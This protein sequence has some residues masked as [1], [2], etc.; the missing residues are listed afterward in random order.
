M[1]TKKT[2]AQLLVLPAVLV[3]L[4]ASATEFDQPGDGPFFGEDANG[5][6]LIGAKYVDMNNRDDGLGEEEARNAGIIL[7]YEFA[8]PVWKGKAAFEFQYLPSIEWGDVNG[9]DSS[10]PSIYPNGGRWENPLYSGYVAY[11]TPGRIYAK[12]K[13][14]IVASRFKIETTWGPQTEVDIIGDVPV[15]DPETG[16]PTG[17]TEEGVIGTELVGGTPGTQRVIQE[18]KTQIGYGLGLGVH[19]GRHFDL[20]LEYEGNQG[21]S[22]LYNFGINAIVKLP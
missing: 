3:T 13:V 20:E 18:N 19:I 5:Q 6:W 14:G 22:Q 15:L 2:F 9:A 17:E 8:R 11:R 12:G 7:G 10:N 16:E 1:T 21:K 4:S